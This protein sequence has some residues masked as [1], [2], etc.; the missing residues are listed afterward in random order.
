MVSTMPARSSVAKA[1]HTAPWN[2]LATN[3]GK[4]CGLHQRGF[5]LTELLIGSTLGLIVLAGALRL[6]QGNAL[7]TAASLRLTRL[8]YEAREL[9][10]HMAVDAR[11]SGYWAGTPGLDA[12]ADNPFMQAPHTLRTGRH[13]G[14]PSASC[15]LYSY[16][17]NADR[18][19]G[20]GS[21]TAVGPH[22]NRA[23]M[24]LFGFRL[25]RGRLQQRQGGRHHGC[26]AGRWQNL[27]GSDTRVTRLEF[28]LHRD[29]L[30]LQRLGQACR[31]GEPAQLLR[32][33]DI[34]LRAESRSD[35]DVSVTLQTRVRLANDRLL[36]Q[37]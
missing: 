12:P 10:G 18:E 3:G 19:V 34:R 26:D 8:N 23:N 22:T 4:K 13:P 1:S 33:L 35:P 11:R 6:Y 5:T 27:T 7:A 2:R 31:R 21:L 29:C 17:L 14:E 24:E 25:S 16:D 37:W 36:R 9:L 15:L 32:R 28:R 30:N 20:I